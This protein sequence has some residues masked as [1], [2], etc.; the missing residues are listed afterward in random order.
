M[1]CTVYKDLQEFIANLVNANLNTCLQNDT[2]AT[3]YRPP[4]LSVN[5]HLNE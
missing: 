3:K 1:L 2:I 5:Y 4:Q